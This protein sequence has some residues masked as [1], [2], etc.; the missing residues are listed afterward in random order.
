[1]AKLY[2]RYG[3][4]GSSK[5]ANA[6]MVRYNYIEKGQ[7]VILLKPKIENRDGEN[8]IKSRIGLSAECG[9]V[10]DF[11]DEVRSQTTKDESEWKKANVVIIDEAQF[12][13]KEQVDELARLVDE[14]HISVI[15]YG[16][17]TDFTSHLFDG[18]KRLMELA[19]VIEE[20]PT[21]CWCGKKAQ[22]NAR[23]KS[24]KIVRDGE[25]IEM[26]GNES[27]VSLCRKHYMSGKIHA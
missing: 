3:A 27:Y 7:K 13:R 10:E 4:M 18:A 15:C 21:I 23:V 6:L 17:R 12:L 16:L 26:G 8:I 11:L 14:Y 20:I 1:M 25:Q 9:L 2:F 5:T 22:F 19:D 24:G